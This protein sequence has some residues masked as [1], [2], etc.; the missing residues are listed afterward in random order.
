METKQKKAPNRFSFFRLV[1]Y[2]GPHL[3]FKRMRGEGVTEKQQRDAEFAE[4]MLCALL[5]VIISLISLGI[6]MVRWLR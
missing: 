4:I 3:I 2:I 1:F 5:S 6:T